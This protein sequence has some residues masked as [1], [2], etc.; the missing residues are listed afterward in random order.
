MD[1]K[2]KIIY[3]IIRISILLLIVGCVSSYYKNECEIYKEKM[4]EAM[5][6]RDNAK[7]EAYNFKNQKNLLEYELSCNR[8]NYSDVSN[9]LNEAL[10]QIDWHE[11]RWNTLVAQKNNFF[12]RTTDLP[13]R[14]ISHYVG[15]SS[16][17]VYHTSGC[18]LLDVIDEDDKVAVELTR[19]SGVQ[20]YTKC[21]WCLK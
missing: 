7:I 14:S 18:D 17:M 10:E 19:F 13:R 20:G 15:D 16:T 6:E 9:E 3:S 4:Y 12:T 2:K 1:I 8:S 11:E 21:S 5:E